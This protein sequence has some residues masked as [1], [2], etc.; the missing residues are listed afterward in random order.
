MAPEENRNEC[1]SSPPT[2][3]PAAGGK[4]AGAEGPFE[5]TLPFFLS[6]KFF[7]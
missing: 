1:L 6:I 5:A 4:G 2:P 3:I 7:L